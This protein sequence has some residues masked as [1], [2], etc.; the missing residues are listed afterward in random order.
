MNAHT[1]LHVVGSIQ[2][3][4]SG[5]SYSVTRL[6]EA[7]AACGLDATIYS[8][9][10]QPGRE[11]H[12][13]V[14]RRSF[15]YS[16]TGVPGLSRL[17]VSHD[18]RRALDAAAAQGAL[19]H[20]HGLWRM[21]N[22]YPGRIAARHG[23][24]L[25]FAPRGMLGTEAL[26]FSALQKRIFWR[27]AQGPALRSVRCFHA[28]AQS[29][30]DDIR[31]FGLTAP[32]AVIPNGI[33]VPNSA[34]LTTRAREVLHLGRIH[35]K[36]GIT[37]L[38]Q[39]W[40]KIEPAFPNW[41]LRI[42]GPSENGHTAELQR[43][44]TALGLTRIRFE[45]PLYGD[46][47]QAAYARAALFVLPTLH[48]NFGLVVAEALAQATPVICTKGAPWAGLETQGCG[49]W[50]DHGHET[51][52]ETLRQAMTTVPDILAEMGLKGQAWMRRDFGWGGIAAKT[53][54]LYD[55]CRRGGPMPGFVQT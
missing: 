5:P 36:K 19:L 50:I 22:V 27:L 23:V 44:A 39:A 32:V 52:A 37:R 35:P 28:T 34:P 24:P 43:Q 9:A 7:Q 47:K 46:D 40:A 6:A 54:A 10:D 41:S 31:T 4:A 11:K 42:V 51:L 29:E 38:V 2:D 20:V 16:L 49:W 8:L 25:V 45:G 13:G 14:D 3:E 1:C 17:D 30:V 15:A 18:L 33:D 12:A 55:W 26:A 21:P 48:E 53:A